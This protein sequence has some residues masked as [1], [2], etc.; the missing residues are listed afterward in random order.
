MPTP[1][2]A[3]NMSP[4]SAASAPVPNPGAPQTNAPPSTSDATEGTLATM[5]SQLDEV[6]NSSAN[7]HADSDLKH[8]LRLVEA[9]LG[10]ASS[11]FLA[12]RC[13]HQGTASHSLRVA[14]G[15]SSWAA[16]L[17]LDDRQRDMLEI[18]A[19]LHDVGKI[20]VDDHI[21]AKPNQ[22]AADE[23]LK[24]EESWGLGREIVS[25]CCS[26]EEILDII[27][28]SRA[29]YDGTK[30]GFDR[31]HKELPFGARLVAIMDAYDS[32]TTDSVYRRAMSRERAA[33]ELFEFAD[34]Q[35]DPD[36]V[37]HFYHLLAADQLQLS[38][39][40]ARRWLQRLDTDT[41]TMWWSM[42]QPAASNSGES[43][44]THN[45]FHDQLF[46]SMHDG[47]VFVDNNLRIMLWNRALERLTGICDATVVGQQWDPTLVGMHDEQNRQ[48]TASDCPVAQT[49]WSGNPS[50]QRLSIQGRNEQLLSVDVHVA[51]VF[52]KSGEIQGATLILH[53]ASSQI[54]LE[55]RVESLN[56]RATLD[57]LTKVNNRAEF[58]RAH[59]EFVSFHLRQGLPCSLIMCDIDHFKKINDTYGHQAGD[60]VLINYAGLLK[61]FA[62]SG[63]VVARYGG[64]EF[65]VLCAECDNTSATRLADRMRS[66]IAQTPQQALG[67]KCITCSMGVTELQN[68]DTAETML[69]RADRALYQAKDGGRNQ[70]VQLGSGIDDDDR[71]ENKKGSSGWFNWFQNSSTPEAAVIEQKLITAVPLGIAAE[72]LRGFVA[73]QQAE[74]ESIEENHVVLKI[75]SVAASMSRRRS[76]RPV[77]FFVEVNLEEVHVALEG[78]RGGSACRTLCNVTVRPQKGRDRR[79][80]DVREIGARLLTSLKSYLM[81]HE[82]EEET[83]R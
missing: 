1:D 34:R 29:W 54:S 62:R 41:A 27:Y 32:M 50:L 28:Y 26:E 16:H 22:L 35:F 51:P 17:E 14:L 73:D 77:P 66:E 69:R 38:P 3:I 80:D 24:M 9:K 33:A 65:V 12:L 60:D 71:A 75:T 46:E 64:E 55:E 63:D 59:D 56:K 57:P 6:Q 23:L 83:V 8:Q 52:A 42:E 43:A 4:D 45:K 7:P 30:H 40:V 48:I 47:V 70:V 5:L 78:R 39:E 68:G 21:L 18:A 67:G 82:F 20:G 76:D 49:I 61:Q 36:L 31:S 58:D 13:K 72:K 81:A 44:L 53:D 74:I 10:I 37:K 19:L 15:C 11:L 79:R 25:A 2:P